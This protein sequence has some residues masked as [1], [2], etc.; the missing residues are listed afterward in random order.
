MASK[1]CGSS[2]KTIKNEEIMQ[3]E[4]FLDYNWKLPFY[5]PTSHQ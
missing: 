5:G 1:V 3:H 4:F 2:Y